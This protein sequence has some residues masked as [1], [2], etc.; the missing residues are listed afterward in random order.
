M[1]AV[2]PSHLLQPGALV[3]VAVGA[4]AFAERYVEIESGHGLSEFS[5]AGVSA[6][7]AASAFIAFTVFRPYLL[8][9]NIPPAMLY[10]GS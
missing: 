10:H 9:V 3:E 8:N 5:G 4:D 7:S 2:T 1:A 6:G